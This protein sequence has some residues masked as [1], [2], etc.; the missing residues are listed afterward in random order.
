MAKCLCLCGWG[1]PFAPRCVPMLKKCL[2]IPTSPKGR[3]YLLS[4]GRCRG[5]LRQT[6]LHVQGSE[7]VLFGYQPV[8]ENRCS[9][10]FQADGACN[11]TR[12]AATACRFA[13]VRLVVSRKMRIFDVRPTW[14][15]IR[16]A[17]YVFYHD[18]VAVSKRNKKELAK[19]VCRLRKQ[20]FDEEQIRVK[21]ASRFGYVKHAN[22]I[23]LS[24]IGR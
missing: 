17:G 22:S 16:L 20:G 3:N 5:R 8:T 19:R 7:E 24:Q 21:L 10:L 6:S 11:C 15:G 18:H 14:T 4:V 1:L 2:H 23:H 13:A 9:Q 12:E